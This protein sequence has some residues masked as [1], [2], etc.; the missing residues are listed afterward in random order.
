MASLDPCE[1]N[2]DRVASHPSD[3]SYYAY[4]NVTGQV[5]ATDCSRHSPCHHRGLCGKVGNHK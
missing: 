2:S 4:S 1:Q 3:I 5:R